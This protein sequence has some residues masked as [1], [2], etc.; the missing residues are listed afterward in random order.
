MYIILLYIHF[1]LYFYSLLVIN[2]ILLYILLFL[3][4]FLYW[5]LQILLL[6][7]SSNC[8]ILFANFASAPLFKIP[9]SPLSIAIATLAR[10]SKTCIYIFRHKNFEAENVQ[11]FPPQLMTFSYHIICGRTNFN[12][13]YT[14]IWFNI[15]NI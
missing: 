12:L 3:Y 10:I 9:L 2:N 13:S 7:C 15:W 6:I 5:F 14:Y 11:R 1:H 4:L 8:A